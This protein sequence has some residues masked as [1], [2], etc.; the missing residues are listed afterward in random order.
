MPDLIDTEGVIATALLHDVPEDFGRLE[1][2]L[3]AI[4]RDKDRDFGHE[5]AR[6][7]ELLNKYN[8]D[9]SLKDEAP[10]WELIANDVRASIVKPADRVHNLFTMNSP[11]NEGGEPVFALPK[12]VEYADYAEHR[13]LPMMK[14]ARNQFPEQGRA[15]ENMK[16]MLRS[17]IGLVRAMT[18]H[19]ERATAAKVIEIKTGC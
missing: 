5:V 3:V 7:S 10:M 1:I 8:R 6:S 15:Y 12:Q 17:Q 13:V 9:A 11:K 18:A 2:E 4:F 19:V 14:I 16:W